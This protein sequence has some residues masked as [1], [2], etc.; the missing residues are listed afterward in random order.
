MP[1]S[2]PIPIAFNENE[3]GKREKRLG[4][5]KEGAPP[6][7]AILPLL[8]RP[9]P[10]D[11]ER[12]E[13]SIDCLELSAPTPVFILTGGYDFFGLSCDLLPKKE[14]L[15]PKSFSLMPLTVFDLLWTFGSVASEPSGK[16][17]TLANLGGT[18]LM[19]GRP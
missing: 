12:R 14:P 18:W 7:P 13:E 11:M 9:K 6:E 17:A 1:Y 5:S 15:R 3:A 10:K 8:L 19:L 4:F 2:L 16:P